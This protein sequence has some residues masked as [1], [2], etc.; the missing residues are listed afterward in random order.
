MN[1]VQQ[2]SREVKQQQSQVNALTE[3]RSKLHAEL[4]FAQNQLQQAFED[5]A[6][7]K[8]RCEQLVR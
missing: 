3:E 4:T 7:L 2:K 5:N 8:Q 6:Q 1:Q